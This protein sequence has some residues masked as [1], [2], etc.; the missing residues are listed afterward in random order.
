MT[1]CDFIVAM[2]RDIPPHLDEAE[3]GAAGEFD[4][5][6][7]SLACVHSE[8]ARCHPSGSGDRQSLPL[9]DFPAV[10]VPESTVLSEKMPGRYFFFVV[11]H[12][13]FLCPG[14]GGESP[15]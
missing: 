12:V 10:I 8:C 6:H 7:Q 11:D 4:R 14:K 13:V 1:A 15:S 3:N 5:V 2:T 9:D